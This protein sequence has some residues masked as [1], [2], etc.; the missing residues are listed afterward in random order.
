MTLG[1]IGPILCKENTIVK[2][3]R[4]LFKVPPCLSRYLKE[5]FR[6][7]RNPTLWDDI[8]LVNLN[9]NGYE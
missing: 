4:N 5:N 7:L 1:L 3:L 8:S 6:V 9:E 2:D